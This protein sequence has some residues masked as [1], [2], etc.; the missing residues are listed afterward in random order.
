MWIIRI[1]KCRVS[2][3]YNNTSLKVRNVYL[4]WLF[5]ICRGSFGHTLELDF[6]Q[7]LMQFLSR[8]FGSVHFTVGLRREART[9]KDVVI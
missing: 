9:R 3:C 1:C 7:Q 5:R 8:K 2:G 6:L 4:L